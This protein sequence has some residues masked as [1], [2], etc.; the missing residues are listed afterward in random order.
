MQFDSTPLRTFSVSVCQ[1][2]N[3]SVRAFSCSVFFAVP[4]TVYFKKAMI[5]LYVKS[6][7]FFHSETPVV[8]LDQNYS[9]M[10]SSRIFVAS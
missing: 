10:D 9:Y 6:T 2:Y 7:G 5:A 4:V 1:I 8:V 3:G